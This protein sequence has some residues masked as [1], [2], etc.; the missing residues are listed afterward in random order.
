MENN[1]KIQ[2]FETVGE[3][4]KALEAFDDDTLLG[5]INQPKQDL[6]FVRPVTIGNKDFPAMLGFQ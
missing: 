5:F 1:I 3:L 4:R 6:W 2:E